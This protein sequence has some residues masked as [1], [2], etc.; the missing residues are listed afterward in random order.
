MWLKRGLTAMSEKSRIRDKLA[1][2]AQNYLTM[3]IWARQEAHHAVKSGWREIFRRE[4]QWRERFVMSA[5]TI[6]IG[7]L[8]KE[9]H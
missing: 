1:E 3:Y 8:A 7:R 6:F 2:L 9:Q 5:A 4:H